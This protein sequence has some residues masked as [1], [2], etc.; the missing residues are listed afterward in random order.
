MVT[1]AAVASASRGA[2][3][4]HTRITDTFSSDTCLA[5]AALDAIAGACLFGVVFALTVYAAL[6]GGALDV[7]TTVDALSFTAELACAA[8]DAAAWVG[9][10][11]LVDA[12]LPAWAAL[13]IA[14]LFFAFSGFTERTIG[15]GDKEASIDTFS[16]DAAFVGIAGDVFAGIADTDTIFTS[17][18]GGAFAL[19]AFLAALSVATDQ[20]SGT[21]GVSAGFVV[22]LTVAVV[23]FAVADL[24]AGFG[25]AAIF[26]LAVFTDL[27]AF[28]TGRATSAGD[29][30]VDHAVAIVVFAVTGFGFGGRARATAP[31][32][33]LTGGGAFS[34]RAL[35]RARRESV[36]DLS[37]TIVVF[38][39]AIFGLWFGGITKGP[40]TG[41]T[42][43]FSASTSGRASAFRDVVVDLAVTVVIDVVA[44]FGRGLTGATAFPFAA[45]ANFES[46][47]AG[48][49]TSLG[50]VFVDQSVAI[51][52]DPI[53]DL[54]RRGLGGSGTLGS[55]AIGLADPRSCIFT[56]ACADFAGLSEGKEEVCVAKRCRLKDWT[57]S[58]IRRFKQKF[59]LDKT[60]GSDAEGLPFSGVKAP[61]SSCKSGLGQRTTRTHFDGFLGAGV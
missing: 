37:V 17:E 16:S 46:C 60:V 36:V 7:C 18:S 29:A 8:F 27:F 11:L 47:A 55:V 44:L 24:V 40:L 39:V 15:T 50:E 12:A 54:G 5:L 58:T 30:V 57:V 25:G 10:A 14:A 35:A 2:L 53:A 34:T 32:S 33:A 42:A 13:G 9:D 31:F 23:V 43:F 56:S 19:V 41:N 38:A 52:V 49:A 26:P 4:T 28:A 6:F 48:T 21:K 59:D 22:D 1:N 61:S 3:D 45:F 51:V 20:S